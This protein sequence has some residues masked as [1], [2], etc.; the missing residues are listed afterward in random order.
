MTGFLVANITRKYMN[1]PLVV[2]ARSKL[3]LALDCR[4]TIAA[5]AITTYEYACALCVVVYMHASS[6]NIH[7]YVS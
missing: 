3:D 5:H 1:V 2:L 4:A 6:A 7:T